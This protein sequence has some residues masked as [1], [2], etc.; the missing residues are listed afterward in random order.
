MTM[1]DRIKATLPHGPSTAI[2]HDASTGAGGSV[3]LGDA[4]AG[5]ALAEAPATAES[6]A[7]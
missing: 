2:E 1:G 7:E 6:L 3:G 5:D 4:L